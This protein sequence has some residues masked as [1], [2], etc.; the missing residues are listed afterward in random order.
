MLENMYNFPIPLRPLKIRRSSTNRS[1]STR[2]KRGRF[3]KKGNPLRMHK[4]DV[5]KERDL[6]GINQDTVEII[7]MIT[8]RDY[9]HPIGSFMH[10]AHRYPG[11]M[12]IMERVIG[13]CNISEATKKFANSL[14]KIARQVNKNKNVFW[15]DCKAGIDNRFDI[16]IGDLNEITKKISNYNPGSIRE[17]ISSVRNLLR[18]P[19]YNVLV[20]LV[21]SNPTVSEWEELREGLRKHYILRWTTDDILRGWKML[22]GKRHL[23]LPDA[24]RHQSIVKVDLWAPVEGKYNEITNYFQVIA[25][26]KTGKETIINQPWGDRKEMLHNDILKYSSK[27]HRNSLKLAKRLWNLAKIT[28]DVRTLEKLYPLFGSDVASLNQIKAESEVIRN[29]IEK[30]KNPPFPRLMEQ[31]EGFKRRINDASFETN[32]NPQPFYNSI[33]QIIDMYKRDKRTINRH[34]IDKKLNQLETYLMR[35]IEPFSY[36]FLKNI[37]I[38]PDNLKIDMKIKKK[39]A[40]PTSP[41]GK[42]QISSKFY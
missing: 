32:F 25:R 41:A 15:G 33:N 5:L 27:E 2:S 31:I 17:N 19:E 29:M 9:T 6:H 11:D 4:F 3:T 36:Q 10:R 39:P 42:S 13:C 28:N 12:D 7:Q 23:S 20:K 40:R 26:N 21:K 30:I 34:Y 22:P 18:S 14:K 35:V 1:S 16:Y 24:L 38:D 37:K 8:M